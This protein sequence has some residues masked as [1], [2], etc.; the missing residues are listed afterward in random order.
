[1]AKILIVEDDVSISEML[2]LAL[3]TEHA[4]T[5]AYSGTEGLLQ[6]RAT[7]F[8]CILLDLMLPGKSG[9]EV[10]T[11]IRLTSNVPVIILTA[12]TDK[13]T[14]TNLLLAGANDYVSK[15]FDMQELRA[16]IMVQLRN[17]VIQQVSEEK[18][19]SETVYK[20]LVVQR[21]N[22]SATLCG[23]PLSLSRKEFEILCLLLEQPKRVFT[24]E[25]VY[26]QVWGE[27]SYGDE[28][29]VNVHISKLRAKLLKIDADNQY[30]E[31]VWGIGIKLAAV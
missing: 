26:T 5:V 1:M 25:M 23:E 27:D 24:K 16:R 17:N 22:Y 12:M 19:T 2:A 3:G 8:D 11:E 31:T 7:S 6:C 18:A 21:E 14:T 10:L 15:P 20:N 4:C 30:I 28:N 9:L 29:T 13:E